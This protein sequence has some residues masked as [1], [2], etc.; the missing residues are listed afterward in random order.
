MPQTAFQSTTI[1]AEHYNE[2]EHARSTEIIF[3][4]LNFN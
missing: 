3:I 1:P 4:L 2:E